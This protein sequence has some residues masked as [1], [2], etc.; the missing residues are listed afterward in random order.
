MAEHDAKVIAEDM[1]YR[2]ANIVEIELEVALDEARALADVFEAEVRYLKPERS[3]ANGILKHFIE[4]NPNFLA[5][6]VTDCHHGR[7]CYFNNNI[8]G[9]FSVNHHF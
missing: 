7:Y 9:T 4:K 3:H 8:R 2:Y 1:A 5:D 6:D